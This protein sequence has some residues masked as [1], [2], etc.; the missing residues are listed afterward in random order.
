MRPARRPIGGQPYAL[1]WFPEDLAGWDPTTD[2]DAPFM[3]STT[4]LAARIV[5][6]HTT[7]NPSA[8]PLRVTALSVFANTDGNPAQGSSAYDY[9]TS[10]FWQY[11]DTLVF[12]GGSASEGLILTPNPTITDAAHRNGVPVYGTVFFPPNVFGGQLSWVQSLLRRDG[13]GFPAARALA[14]IASYCGFEGWFVNQETDGA[15]AALAADMR[16]FLAELRAAGSRVYWYDAMNETGEVGWQGALN[17]LNDDFYAVSN[18]MFVDFRWDIPDLAASAAYAESMGRDPAELFAGVDTGFRQF[19]VQVDFDLIAPSG[20]S[21][22][23]YRPDFT[24]TGTDDPSQYDARE[25]RFWVGIDG[26][27]S[28]SVAYSDE[29]L[30]VSAAVSEHTVVTR[31]PFVTTFNTGHG[32]G[33]WQHGKRWQSGDWNQL[34]VQDVL[35][36]WRWLAEDVS[37]DHA[38]AWQGGSS[39]HLGAAT[40]IP[41]YASR[42]GVARGTRIELQAQGAAHV[43]AVLRF[44]DAPATDVVVPLGASSAGWTRLGAGLSRFAGRTLIRIGVQVSGAARIG[45]LALLDRAAPLPPPVTNVRVQRFG[46]A[47]RIRWDA[48]VSG[49]RY[50]VEA[51]GARRR[52]L[53][54]TTGEALYAW[55]VPSWARRIDVVPIAADG[56]RGTAAIGKI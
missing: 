37:L 49:T 8:T 10:E 1:N 14:R 45:R 20:V 55:F 12:W 2:P 9:Y 41:L 4:P 3:V 30:G 54:S 46:D 36:T 48:G 33:W 19:D 15:D 26:D 42:I 5:D 25:S 53:G 31:T 35:P 22:G 6:E 18:L 28:T 39:L 23:L 51:V 17:E 52:W 16:D 44:L 29:W 7:A 24:L 34:T 50:D 56:R 38:D 32:H 11:I 27:P 13:S 43:D 47:A 40:R 21:V